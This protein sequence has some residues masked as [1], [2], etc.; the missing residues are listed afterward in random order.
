M[1]RLG[2]V[3]PYRATS[4]Y[5]QLATMS[6]E[7]LRDKVASRCFGQ[8]KLEDLEVK[9]H[10]L[11]DKAHHTRSVVVGKLEKQLQK[12]GSDPDDAAAEEQRKD[13]TLRL[14]AVEA[15]GHNGHN[16]HGR[17]KTKVVPAAKAREAALCK[18]D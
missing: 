4:A 2:I 11:E 5:A 13:L 6:T 9:L 7:C 1:Y 15:H 3:L 16:G 14:R 17:G 8:Q 10:S 12:I 18:I